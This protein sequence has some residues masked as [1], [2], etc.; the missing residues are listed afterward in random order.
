[1]KNK[2]TVVTGDNLAG[3]LGV[4]VLGSV[5]DRTGFTTNWGDMCVE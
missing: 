5:I 3:A 2:Q 1:M 4:S